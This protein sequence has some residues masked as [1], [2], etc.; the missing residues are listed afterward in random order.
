MLSIFAKIGSGLFLIGTKVA[1]K[2]SKPLAGIEPLY[3][4]D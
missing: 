2:N 3:H 1:T 4:P